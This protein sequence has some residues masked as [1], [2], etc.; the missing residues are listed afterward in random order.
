MIRYL[1]VHNTRQCKGLVWGYTRNKYSEDWVCKLSWCMNRLLFF[2]YIFKHLDNI[3]RAF[4]S[5]LPVYVARLQYMEERFIEELFRTKIIKRAIN[6]KYI[7]KYTTWR[8]VFGQPCLHRFVEFLV[9]G[10][11]WSDTQ[12]HLAV[13]VLNCQTHATNDI[14][15]VL[16]LKGHYVVLKKKLKLRMLTLRILMRK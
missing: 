14:T 15:I 2:S 7:F 5:P 9:F 10:V 6:T 8:N 3:L 12:L 4:F 11:M 13:D 16:V 1:Q